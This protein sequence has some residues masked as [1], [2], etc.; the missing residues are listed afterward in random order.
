M[1][2]VLRKARIVHFTLCDYVDADEYIRTGRRPLKENNGNLR[3]W[4]YEPGM[5][6]EE[7]FA[8]N[9]WD[10]PLVPERSPQFV[11]FSWAATVQFSAEISEVVR[12]PASKRK[13]KKIE[14]SVL[15]PNHS[16]Y[17]QYVNKPTPEWARGYNP[18]YLY[19]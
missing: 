11:L 18:R 6:D 8:L 15:S 16:I 2:K 17:S 4:G 10:W 12:I 19:E 9:R 5:G 14:G 3:G 7:A 13:L 1:P